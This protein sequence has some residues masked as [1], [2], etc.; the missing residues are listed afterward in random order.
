LKNVFTVRARS[1]RGVPRER[2]RTGLAQDLFR[3]T[4]AGEW[5]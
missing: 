4:S 5:A 2:W 3:V 1:L